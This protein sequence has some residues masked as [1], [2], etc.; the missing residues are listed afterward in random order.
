MKMR[1]AEQEEWYRE[2]RAGMGSNLLE[3]K[4]GENKENQS[5]TQGG[6]GVEES[7]Q[8]QIF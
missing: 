8:F 3:V 5:E 4:G 2:R 6:R 1:G 7:E